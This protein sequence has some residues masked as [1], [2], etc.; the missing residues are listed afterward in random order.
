MIPESYRSQNG[1]HNCKHVYERVD[2][3]TTTNN[4]DYYC[5]FDGSE[6][7]HSGSVALES[8]KGFDPVKW[9]EWGDSHFVQPAGI[10]AEWIGRVDA[11]P[12]EVWTPETDREW[13]VAAVAAAL[14]TQTTG[15][16][17]NANNTTGQVADNGSSR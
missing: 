9:Y 2:Y 7:P 17:G 10:C 16:N 14:R 3:D 11:E 8:D 13:Q 4:G 12:D 6:R 5:T 15:N 1:C